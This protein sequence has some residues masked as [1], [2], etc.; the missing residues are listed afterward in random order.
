MKHNNGKLS[1]QNQ[2]LQEYNKFKVYKVNNNVRIE[3]IND[4][5]IIRYIRKGNSYRCINIIRKEFNGK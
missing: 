3:I 5:L 1:M 2:I 4:I